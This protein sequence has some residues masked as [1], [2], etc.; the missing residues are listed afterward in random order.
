[1]KTIISKIISASAAVVV[2]CAGFTAVPKP[3][4]DSSPD[5]SVTIIEAKPGTSGD[6][7]GEGNENNPQCDDPCVEIL[8]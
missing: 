6:E 4:P 5:G 1:M 3:N 2:L 7:S 8:Q